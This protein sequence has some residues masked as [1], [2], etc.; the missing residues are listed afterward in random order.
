MEHS[1]KDLTWLKITGSIA[2]S[3]IFMTFGVLEFMTAFQAT[4]EWVLFTNT[5]ILGWTGEFMTGITL[6]IIGLLILWA[7]PLYLMKKSQ[8]A[9][10]FFLIGSGLGVIFGLVFI[11]IFI[12]DIITVLV[13]A[14]ANATT[15]DFTDFSSLYHPITYGIALVPIFILL[16]LEF[17]KVRKEAL[18]AS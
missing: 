9:N 12:A 7:T 11:F 15:L 10:S 17:R 4:E 18:P 14:A 6:F 13:D 2:F 16:F 8:N 3:L 5:S 1:N